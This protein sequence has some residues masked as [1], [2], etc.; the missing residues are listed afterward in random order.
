V[1]SDREPNE[2]R[3]TSVM[4]S[5]KERVVE[6]DRE[7]EKVGEKERPGRGYTCYVKPAERQQ[8]GLQYELPFPNTPP[9]CLQECVY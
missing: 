8:R 4:A 1:E 5:G 9:S 3:L 6:R 7:R 2:E